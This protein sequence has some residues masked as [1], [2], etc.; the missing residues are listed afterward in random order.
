MPLN[1]HFFTTKLLRFVTLPKK[2]HTLTTYSLT[3]RIR[4]ILL[5]FESVQL[6]PR[7]FLRIRRF[8]WSESN[9]SNVCL[10]LILSCTHLSIYWHHHHK[11]TG[12]VLE[13]G[14]MFQVQHLM[15]KFGLETTKK[16]SRQIHEQQ[17]DLFSFF[18]SMG[19]K[20]HLKQKS[21]NK[22]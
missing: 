14:K 11:K 7:V 17:Y 1:F 20:P 10:I 15:S 21:R 8:D 9:S 16:H 6:Q 2:T 22:K 18:F 4:H 3:P 13:F 5:L 19:I 12:P